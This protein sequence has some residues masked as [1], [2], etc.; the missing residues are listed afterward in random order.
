M[1]GLKN[2][3]RAAPQR[4]APSES[5]N[6]LAS[7]KLAETGAYGNARSRGFYNGEMN[8]HWWGPLEES[9]LVTEKQARR[10]VRAV[11]KRFP[12]E[13]ARGLS[14][15]QVFRE[16]PDWDDRWDDEF[17]RGRF[18]SYI[19]TLRADAWPGCPGGVS[20]ASLMNELACRLLPNPSNDIEDLNWHDR[21]EEMREELLKFGRKVLRS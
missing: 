11:I 8:L 21:L 13:A 18:Y 19:F 20:M 2:E 1:S 6:H 7:N 10:F 9:S 5:T 17:G 12:C 14:E 16:I 4:T 15:E 3:E